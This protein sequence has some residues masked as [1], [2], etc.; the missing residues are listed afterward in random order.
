VTQPTRPQAPTIRT[1]MTRA[2]FTT[3]PA[4][5]KTGLIVQKV[6]KQ[7]MAKNV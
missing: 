3:H 5:I 4:K 6:I 7:E 2:V 1:T